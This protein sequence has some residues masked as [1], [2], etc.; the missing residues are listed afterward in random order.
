MYCC[1]ITKQP[2]SVSSSLT[3]WTPPHLQ[4]SIQKT[5]KRHWKDINFWWLFHVFLGFWDQKPKNTS[6]SHQ[7]LMSFRIQFWTRRGYF[8][9]KWPTYSEIFNKHGVFLI[10]FEEKF[11]TTCLIRTST[12]INFWWKI[13]ST[14]LIEPPRLFILG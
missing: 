9:I 3:D 13:P 5:L 1:I 7:K 12:F 4:N 2:V 14:R 6:K 8:S 10:L 11:L